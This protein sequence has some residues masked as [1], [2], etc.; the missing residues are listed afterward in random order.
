MPPINHQSH[1][2]TVRSEWLVIREQSAFWLS[3][4]QMAALFCQWMVIEADDAGEL[5]NPIFGLPEHNELRFSDIG[6]VRVMETMNTDLHGAISWQWDR[7]PGF[8]ELVLGSLC[9]RYCS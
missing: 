4:A 8:R 1:V 7:P 2:G 9:R 3:T 5:P 6:V